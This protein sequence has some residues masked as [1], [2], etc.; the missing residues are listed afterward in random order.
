MG[1]SHGGIEGINGGGQE[2]LDGEHLGKATR[3]KPWMAEKEDLGRRVEKDALMPTISCHP[4]N[5][6]KQWLIP[7]TEPNNKNGYP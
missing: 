6:T 2:G 5:Q 4:L 7:H 3:E 1:S